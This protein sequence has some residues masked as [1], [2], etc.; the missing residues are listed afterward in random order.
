MEGTLEPLLTVRDVAHR[1]G[2]SRF[3]VNALVRS[4]ALPHVRVGRAIRVHPE[5]LRYFSRSSQ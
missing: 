3:T 4:G 2:V 5:D 1:L